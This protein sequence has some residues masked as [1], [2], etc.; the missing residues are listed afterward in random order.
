MYQKLES[1]EELRRFFIQN[2][3]VIYKTKENIIILYRILPSKSNY[4]QEGINKNKFPKH[5]IKI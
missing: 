3:V 4:I 2:Y 5:E 1:Q